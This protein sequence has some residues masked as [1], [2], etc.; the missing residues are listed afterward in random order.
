M[1][2][3][4]ENSVNIVEMLGIKKFQTNLLYRFVLKF[5]CFE[6]Y[7]HKKVKLGIHE[8]ENTIQ[9][10]RNVVAAIFKFASG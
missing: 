9:S 3:L 2:D 8:R 5:R 1:S 4:S 10:A 6:K 7:A